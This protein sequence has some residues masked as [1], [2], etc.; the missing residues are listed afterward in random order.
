MIVN[1]AS[2]GGRTARALARDRRAGR[3]RTGSTWS[4]D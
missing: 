4:R 1:P 3:A 2:D